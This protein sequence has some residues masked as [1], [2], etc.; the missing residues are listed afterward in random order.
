MPSIWHRSN[1]SQCFQFTEPESKLSQGLLKYRQNSIK[2]IDKFAVA[3]EVSLE[4]TLAREDD[5]LSTYS[6]QLPPPSKKRKPDVVD[7]VYTTVSNKVPA[8]NPFCL[9]RSNTD[10][11][12]SL[13]PLTKTLSPV[14]KPT[15]T[16]SPMKTPTKTLSPVKKS[17]PKRKLATTTLVLSRFFRKPATKT[18]KETEHADNSNQIEI[19]EKFLHVKSLYD[20]SVNNA[21][22][23]YSDIGTMEPTM[24]KQ[25]CKSQECKSDSSCETSCENTVIRD[26]IVEVLSDTEEE[27]PAIK[28][29]LNKFVHQKEVSEPICFCSIRFLKPNSICRSPRLSQEYLALKNRSS[30]QYQL[31]NLVSLNLCSLNGKFSKNKIF[32]KI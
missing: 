15:T 13:R 3:N 1:D 9:S 18:D 21:L 4:E 25:E 2:K 29:T 17:N 22:S 12:T 5:L 6:H 23:L 24:E 28:K 20:N 30:S 8:R 31:I 10:D 11:S 16:L 32:S 7:D 14:K 26:D 19:K 27:Q